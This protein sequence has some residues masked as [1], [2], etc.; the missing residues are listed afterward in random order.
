MKIRFPIFIP[1]KARP[2]NVLT[3]RLLDAEEIP[4][5]VVVEP[6]DFPSYNLAFPEDKLLRLPENDRGIAFSRSWIKDSCKD[7]GIPFH[8]QLDDD[9]RIFYE[10]H[11]NMKRKCSPTPAFLFAESFTDKLANLGAIGFYHAPFIFDG[12]DYPAYRLN[13]AIMTAFLVNSSTP[14]TFR[15]ETVDDYDFTLQNLFSGFVTVTIFK[16]LYQSQQKQFGGCHESEHAGRGRFKLHANTAQLW[17]NVTY[18][19]N[20]SLRV[21]WKLFKHSPTPKQKM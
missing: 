3:A 16:Y 20:D 12:K 2:D 18:M 19:K 1:S 9:I 4:Y 11:G 8:W 21:K 5:K 6:Q 17:P 15:P 14:T 7:A 13:Y 10:R